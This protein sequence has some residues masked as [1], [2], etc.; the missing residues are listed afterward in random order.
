[1]I[2]RTP[3]KI[4]NRNSVV[5][6][7][8]VDLWSWLKEFANGIL[9]INFRENFQSFTVENLVIPP[10]TEVAIPNAFRTAYPGNIPSGRIIIRQ[11]LSGVT[12]IDGDTQWSESHVYLKNPD[13][14]DSVRVSVLFFM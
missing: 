5:K 10:N 8:E 2:I 11:A 1:M 13:L 3:P 12:V 7:V 14:T 9:K 6:Y 4:T